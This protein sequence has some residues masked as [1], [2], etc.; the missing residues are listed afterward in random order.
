MPSVKRS[1]SVL[2]SKQDKYKGNHTQ[3]HH[4]QSAKGKDKEKTLKAAREKFFVCRGI[5]MILRQSTSH[6]K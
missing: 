4:N 2:N 5:D 6:L 1:R 3:I